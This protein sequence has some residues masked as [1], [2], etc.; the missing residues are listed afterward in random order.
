MLM[1][2]KSCR[3]SDPVKAIAREPVSTHWD[4]KF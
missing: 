1:T 4:R 2:T 3:K